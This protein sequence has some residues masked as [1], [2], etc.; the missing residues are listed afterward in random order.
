MIVDWN[1]VTV[2]DEGPA[3]EPEK[4]APPALRPKSP[5]RHRNRWGNRRVH[6]KG[7]GTPKSDLQAMLRAAVENTREKE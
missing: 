7:D 4:P 3:R 6:P 1:R 5:V 2:T